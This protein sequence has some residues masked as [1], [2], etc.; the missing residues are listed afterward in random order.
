MFLVIIEPV[1]LSQHFRIKMEGGE[2]E[3]N[4]KH[5]WFLR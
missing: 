4:I 5:T 2:K 1:K 3:V